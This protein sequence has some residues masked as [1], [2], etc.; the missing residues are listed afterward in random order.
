[1]PDMLSA[2]PGLV[3]HYGIL[4][5][6]NCM[7]AAAARGH[8]KVLEVAVRALQP[9]RFSWQVGDSMLPKPSVV[10]ERHRLLGTLASDA[11]LRRAL[12]KTNWQGMTPL[13]MA[14]AAG[15]HNC[16]AFLLEQGADPLVRDA[17][18]RTALHHA[19]GNGKAQIVRKLLHESTQVE[20]KQRQQPL[21]NVQVGSHLGASSRYMDSRGMWGM[22][23]LHVAVLREDIDC[24][25]A[26][27]EAGV[28][29]SIPTTND[30][31]MNPVT[32]IPAG[33][34]SLHIAAIRSNIAIIQTLLQANA[35]AQNRPG[36]AVGARQAW[37][38]D[39][40]FDL[41][42]M[43]TLYGRMPW[44]LS[45]R[46]PVDIAVLL[47][48]TRPVAAA[49]EDIQVLEDGL[50]PSSLELIAAVAVR[51]GLQA[52]LRGFQSKQTSRSS[53]ELPSS[54]SIPEAPK[55][56]EMEQKPGVQP[57]TSS[58]SRAS[59]LH[60]R[61]SAPAQ[62]AHFSPEQSR[63][64]VKRL[65]KALSLHVRSFSDGRGPARPQPS[66]P[67]ADPRQ[68]EAF[69]FA[70]RPSSPD[71]AL[72]RHPSARRWL[73]PIMSM[74]NISLAGLLAPRSSY[75]QVALSDDEE[76][77]C[78]ICC[79]R[80][81]NVA[82][83]TCGHSM[84]VECAITLCD[85]HKR[86][87]YCPFCR[88][89]RAFAVAQTEALS[90]DI[91]AKCPSALCVY[92]FGEIR[93]AIQADMSA[94]IPLEIFGDDPSVIEDAP[95]DISPSS[96]V[97]KKG[98]LVW[99]KQRDGAVASAK[100]CS[101]DSSVQPFSYGIE[102]G[103][104]FRET[105][106][107]RLAPRGSGATPPSQLP[108][109]VGS[110]PSEP[111]PPAHASSFPAAAPAP[112]ANADSLQTAAKQTEAQQQARGSFPSSPSNPA[113]SHPHPESGPSGRA[114]Q[115]PSYADQR[116]KPTQPSPMGSPWAT[117][118]YFNPY[119]AQMTPEQ[120]RQYLRQYMVAC[121]PYMQ[122]MNP[123][124]QDTYLQQYIQ[125]MQGYQQP[126]QG[127]VASA[128]AASDDHFTNQQRRQQQQQQ[129]QS[130][131]Q[132]VPAGHQQAKQS[133][134]QMENMMQQQQQQ[135]QQQQFSAA[136]A[137]E[138]EDDF[139]TFEAAA[140]P[141]SP[142]VARKPAYDRS[143][144]VPASIFGDDVSELE[145][146]P[147]PA[148][149][150]QPRLAA[151]AAAAAGVDDD[152]GDVWVGSGSPA[153]AAEVSKP[154]PFAAAS[155]SH[156]FQAQVAAARA[157]GA[158]AAEAD[159]HRRQLSSDALPSITLG[160]ALPTP[161][162]NRS[163]SIDAKDHNASRPNSRP[164]S[165]ADA[166]TP[167]TRQPLSLSI[168]GDTTLDQPNGSDL[169]VAPA[170]GSVKIDTTPWGLNTELQ[171]RE[172]EGGEDEDVEPDRERDEGWVQAGMRKVTGGRKSS[173]LK[174]LGSGRRGARLQ[175]DPD[176]LAAMPRPPSGVEGPSRYRYLAAWTRLMQACAK[177]LERGS[178]A[179]QQMCHTGDP[180]EW[181]EEE[182]GLAYLVGLGHIY[183]VVSLLRAAAEHYHADTHSPEFAA[184]SERCDAAWT[185]KADAEGAFALQVAVIMAL[186]HPEANRVGGLGLPFEDLITLPSEAAKQ[187]PI[188]DPGA[189][190]RHSRESGQKLCAFSLLP[191]EGLQD[192]PH[193]RWVD[194]QP[195]LVP[196]ANLWMNRVSDE[197]L[198]LH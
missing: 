120:Q 176:D 121:N 91:P 171:Q 66:S 143:A 30:C 134:R 165:G 58:S 182:S 197:S 38:G 48:P 146:A 175:E 46:S 81:A 153:A 166:R 36:G 139:G 198:L 105:E 116:P 95:A 92:P 131:V 84:C 64:S 106:A 111:A 78:S 63:P 123:E 80:Q 194:G 99:Y 167:S 79:C 101:V 145:D 90:L 42:A 39:A 41:R 189:V 4:R 117:N 14:A 170:A 158:A 77:D 62:R 47:D 140:G 57:R 184:A 93:A 126:Q 40:R 142:A 113:R 18:F 144:P 133:G 12:D 154:S 71:P 26:L 24:V 70:S 192:V 3:T 65:S 45:S 155:Q 118:Y 44:R 86:P 1:M 109:A 8:L 161:W 150:S 164:H 27:L 29:L 75:H 159:V 168:F 69:A 17:E 74:R 157:A 179:W 193:V 6:E 10:P 151:A 72:Q 43:T 25:R 85:Y 50:G 172:S 114:P 183:F 103:D 67:S 115:S 88:K 149:S 160:A 59:R 23:P 100:V 104:H 163:S 127:K 2:Q 110:R 108:T 128:A 125:A 132:A 60:T 162:A 32:P 148:L 56:V 11:R 147:L 89:S 9:S 28:Y 188:L 112:Q 20:G 135:Q 102:L 87:P 124:Q 169:H 190:Q 119:M 138:D 174:R 195:C 180:Q 152:W 21:K 130:A 97:Y 33:C 186:N 173:L 96:R 137:A 156:P 52:W 122:G 76:E 107:S 73:S 141:A 7:H 196:L 13:M 61:Q 68:N 35:E 15:Y 54:D 49:L 191:L 136:T 177:E 19:V 34:T 83:A 31:Q 16:A 185:A 51:N 94:P 178:F 82:V 181:M 187:L 129:G 22:T 37:E 53:G 55:H 98:D 5:Q